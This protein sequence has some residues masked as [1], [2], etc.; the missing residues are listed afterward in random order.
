MPVSINFYNK[1]MEYVGDG[2]ID[3]DTDIFDI[4]LMNSTHSYTAA[5]TNKAD[6]VANEIP[7]NNGYTQGAKTLASITWVESGGVLTW[8]ADDTV[9]TASGGPIPSSGNCSDAV[10]Y[11]EDATSPSAD[12]LMCSIDFGQNESAGSGTNFQITYNA[13]GIFT[14]S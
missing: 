12:L 3:L 14:I 13:S 1:F 8:D 11:D 7:T 2:G 4:I 10:I 5:D 9:W 6:I